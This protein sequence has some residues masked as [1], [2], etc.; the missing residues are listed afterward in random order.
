MQSAFW[1]RRPATEWDEALPVGNGALGAMVHGGTAQE[2][3][4][5]NLDTFW[6]GR[7]HDYDDPAAGEFLGRIRELLFAGAETEASELGSRHFMGKPACQTAYQPLGDLLLSETDSSEGPD[8][9]RDLD[10]T[11]GITRAQYV[12]P[13][14]PRLREVFVSFPDQVLVVRISGRGPIGVTARLHSAF[15]TTITGD[16]GGLLL[17]GQWINDGTER[18]WTADVREP[19]MRFAIGL[20]VLEGSAKIADGCLVASGTGAVTL[21]L[22]AAT[23]F[24]SYRDIGG[25]PGKIVRSRLASALTQS[26][27]DLRH[28]HVADVSSFM[29]RVD[30]DIGDPAL[31]ALPVEERLH[32][33]QKGGTDPGLEALLFQFGRHL[34]LSSSRPGTQPAN[35]QGIWNAD[36]APAWGSKW[37]TNINLQMNYWPAETTNLAECH[38]P[39]FDLID[40]LR[41]TGAQTARRYYDA[42]G[43]VLHHNTDLWRGTA[44]VD[45]V[46]G[47][48]AMG[49]AWLARHLWDHYLFTLDAD[50]L[51]KRAWPAMKG[52]AEFLLDFLVEAPA[53]APG[54]GHLVTCPSHS[55]ENRFLKPDGTE[56][57]FT[58]AATMDL[59]I[60]HDCFTSC[61]AAADVIGRDAA[62]ASFCTQLQQALKRL[63]PLQISPRDGRLQ[64][65]IEDYPDCE[66]GHRHVS[67]AYGLFPGDQITPE[68][69][70]DLAAALRRT[71]DVRLQNGGGGTGWSRAWLINL[72]ARLGDGNAAHEHLA[73]VLA[74]CTL[75]NLFN[76]HPPFQI[77]GN[78]GACAGVAEMLLQSR[79]VSQELFEIRLLPALPAAWRSGKVRGLR[80]RGGFEVAISWADGRLTDATI[81]SLAGKALRVRWGASSQGFHPD[82]GEVLHL[83]ADAV[84]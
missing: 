77:D 18:P 25:E 14:G 56:G 78:F 54:A 60:I 71:L 37:T 38:E 47:I 19:G 27:D 63:P 17:E 15:P 50:F 23:S 75:P 68:T 6:M 22:A 62:D 64:E 39:L 16:G 45:G 11:A 65:W 35:L 74:L 31:A 73:K 10:L 67:H 72:F 9:R 83:K 70:P 3:I 5:L 21:L 8:Y 66:P 51:R 52:A 12:G 36:I 61:L 57:L 34:L 46:W 7:P 30:L 81:K 82:A 26:Y 43:W 20:R 48:W 40:D 55:P 58:Y 32:A 13:A 1:Y 49:A 84:V 4:A 2:R 69:K 79:I 53:G 80:A 42:R 41:A 24:R 44:P 59:M 29:G 33:V 28:R 76:T